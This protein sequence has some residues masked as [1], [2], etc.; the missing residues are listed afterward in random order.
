MLTKINEKLDYVL[1]LP[2]PKRP[3]V[4]KIMHKIYRNGYED[5]IAKG[6]KDTLREYNLQKI[7]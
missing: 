6:K 7:K 1:S 3:E 4:A 2:R 5:G